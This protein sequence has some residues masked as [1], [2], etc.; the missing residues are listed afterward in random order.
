MAAHR[1]DCLRPVESGGRIGEC[2]RH[3]GAGVDYVFFEC[4]SDDWRA[5]SVLCDWHTNRQV[6][7]PRRHSR[8]PA[9]PDN[10]IAGP[11]EEADA[12]IGSRGG[13]VSTSGAVVQV[14]KRKLVAAIVDLIEHSAVSFLGIYG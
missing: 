7:V 5:V 1:E 3:G 2:S 14:S 4:R 9:T 8:I 6:I 13:I 11:H 12:S 10:D